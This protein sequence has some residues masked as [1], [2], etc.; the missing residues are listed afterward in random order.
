MSCV[1]SSTQ[2][3][4]VT[5]GNAPRTFMLI[6]LCSLLFVIYTF[7]L[8]VTIGSMNFIDI[9]QVEDN[10]TLIEAWKISSLTYHNTVIVDFLP[11]FSNEQ[12]LSS[13]KSLLEQ[14][15]LRSEK[16]YQSTIKSRQ[17]WLAEKISNKAGPSNDTWLSDAQGSISVWNLFPPTFNC[18]HGEERIGGFGQRGKWICGLELYSDSQAPEECAIFIFGGDDLSEDGT[19]EEDLIN[20]TNCQIFKFESNT[21]NVEHSRL[22]RFQEARIGVENKNQ[23][24]TFR[25]FMS[26][27]D[28]AWLDMLILDIKGREVTVLE[29]IMKD[30]EGVLPFGQLQMKIHFTSPEVEQ[31]TQIRNSSFELFSRLLNWFEKLENRGLRPFHSEAASLH[32]RDTWEYSGVQGNPFESTREYSFL[33]LRGKHLLLRGHS[34][35]I[36]ASKGSTEPNQLLT[37]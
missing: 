34:T 9:M 13:V 21:T 23:D 8:D 32:G 35:Y 11:F 20:R 33:N 27:N 29:Q 15:L 26:E 5:T 3:T 12:G 19:L 17:D 37:S 25:K 14:N 22:N 4:S 6:T 2:C 36:S 1:P 18:P 28:L 16:I 31:N 7:D 30:F 24:K 10:Q